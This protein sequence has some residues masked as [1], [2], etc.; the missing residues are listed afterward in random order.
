MSEAVFKNIAKNKKAFF[1]YNVLEKFEAGIS[2]SGSEVKSIRNGKVN[3][4]EA[5]IKDNKNELYI[6]GMHIAEYKNKGYVDVDVNR[7]RKLLM[8]KKEIIKL[9]SSIKEKGLSLIPLSLYFKNQNI[10]V[11]IGLCKGKKIYDRREDLKRKAQ[12]REISR[13]IK[14]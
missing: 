14:K 6:V 11:S 2:L 7:D 12:E 3:I 4:K 5:Y 10:K 13:R 1:N 8:H 9:S